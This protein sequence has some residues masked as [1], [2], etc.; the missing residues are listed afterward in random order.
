MQHP[1]DGRNTGK[2]P[3]TT[4]FR[5]AL[6]ARPAGWVAVQ[7]QQ[8]VFLLEDSTNIQLETWAWKCKCLLIFNIFFLLPE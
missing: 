4:R 3:F 5:E 1:K 6:R 8:D 2:L 7:L